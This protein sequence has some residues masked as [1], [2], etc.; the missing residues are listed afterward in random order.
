M[1]KFDWSGCFPYKE[2]RPG[3][4]AAIDACID[5]FE[6]GKKYFILEAGT[7]VGK[8]AVAA[9][10]GAYIEKYLLPSCEDTKT[11]SNILTTQKRFSL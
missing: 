5:A 4:K 8:S 7:G 1:P 2:I 11:G 9:T 10:V 6:S 3:Q